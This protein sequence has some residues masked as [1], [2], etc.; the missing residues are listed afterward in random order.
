MKMKFLT[1]NTGTMPSLVHRHPIHLPHPPRQ[2]HLHRPF[3]ARFI[4]ICADMR[5]PALLAIL[6]PLL[7]AICLAQSKEY[8]TADFPISYSPQAP[9]LL[10]CSDLIPKPAGRAGAIV[11]RDGH[12][13]SGDKRIR[14]WGVNIAFGGNFPTHEQADKLAVRLASFGINA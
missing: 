6:F 7:P 5:T 8:P 10:N 9:G 1:L 4:T 11:P 13:F 3:L 2:I 12:F 14:F